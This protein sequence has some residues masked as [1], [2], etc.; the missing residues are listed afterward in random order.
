MGGSLRIV[1]ARSLLRAVTQGTASGMIEIMRKY[2][3]E[4]DMIGEALRAIAERQRL[5]GEL[6]IAIAHAIGTNEKRGS[7]FQMALIRSV[8]R[9]QTTTE[10]IHAAQLVEA[11]TRKPIDRAD[12]ES[13]AKD[14]EKF[15]AQ[16]SEELGMR[17]VKFVYKE[18]RNASDPRPDKRRKWSNW[19]I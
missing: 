8:S 10:I 19:E 15:I 14:S 12:L 4:L 3:S 13:R 9:I 1:R 18:A 17:T 2:R 11:D 5:N 6:L 7:R 16:K